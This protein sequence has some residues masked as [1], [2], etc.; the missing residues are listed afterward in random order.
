MPR[1]PQRPLEPIRTTQAMPRTHTPHNIGQFRIVRPLRPSIHG[2]RFLAVDDQTNE[3]TTLHRIDTGHEST[4]RRRL[5][6]A[7][8]QLAAFSHSHVLSLNAFTLGE[9]GDLWL[10]TPFTG[11]H[12]GLVLLSDLIELR[13]GPLSAAEVAHAVAQTLDAIEFA[14]K[15]GLSHGPIGLDEIQVGRR[16]SLF[17]EFY[18]L[19]RLRNGFGPANDL[20]IRD[21]IRSVVSLAYK[22]LTGIEASEPRIRASRLMKK[23]DKAWDTWIETGL[24]PF[25]GF[26]NATEAI[27]ALPGSPTTDEPKP[28][29]TILSRLGIASR[30]AA[31]TR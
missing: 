23:T 14:H 30:A 27:N 15:V 31:D 16:G 25:A 2:D 18:G 4:D 1:W 5:L 22:L 6:A 17:I 9:R 7:V 3:N 21:E 13:G 12:E 19:D 10:T 11:N 24:D 28:Q 29:I 26:A 20:L 8:E